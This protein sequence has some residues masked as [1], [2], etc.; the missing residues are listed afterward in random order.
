MQRVVFTLSMPNRGSW[1]GGWSGSENNYTITKRLIDKTIARLGLDKGEQS[2]Y[3][4]WN[5]GWGASI[6]ARIVP[7]GE[8]LKKSDGFCDYNWMVENIIQYGNTKGEENGT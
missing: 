1:N 3:H 5:D 6:S 2:W 8:R 4:N 7:T